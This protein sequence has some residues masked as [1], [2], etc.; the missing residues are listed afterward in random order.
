M[1][2]HIICPKT[3]GLF[4]LS[5][6]NN[7]SYQ[8]VLSASA[9]YKIL[10]NQGKKV[11]VYIDNAPCQIARG[12]ILYCKP[13]NTI[14]VYNVHDDLKVVAYNKDFYE[15]ATAEE[16]AAFY[17]FW[18]FGIKHPYAV[19]L[20]NVEERYMKRMY[21]C[22]EREFHQTNGCIE[23]E[24]DFLK[25]I[26]AVSIGRIEAATGHPV[27]A[28]A[29]LHIIKRFNV[30]IEEHFKKKHSFE[31]IAKLLG[32][33]TSYL[34]QL[35]KKY[36]TIDRLKGLKETL[37]LESKQTSNHIEK[38]FELQYNSRLNPLP[39]REKPQITSS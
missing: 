27:I 19:Q 33:R 20:S 30:L 21:D 28:E 3:G 7:S 11:T 18:Y 37:L 14:Q 32:T 1:Q 35:F 15:L 38:K 25:R 12:D 16:E 29:Q 36:F 8:G 31:D 39:K 9:L 6:F 34:Q 10:Y 17:W 24:R 4:F 26:M 2:H 22:M 5:D 13:L 23:T